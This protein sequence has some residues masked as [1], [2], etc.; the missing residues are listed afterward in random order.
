[1]NVSAL[2]TVS[3]SDLPIPF[4]PVN[5]ITEKEF[6]E[7]FGFDEKGRIP[8]PCRSPQQVSINPLNQC[9]LNAHILVD[10]FLGRFL[11]PKRNEEKGK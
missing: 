1:M 7:L 4:K 9:D 3:P 5:F 10:P 8:R 6:N 11:S 2:T